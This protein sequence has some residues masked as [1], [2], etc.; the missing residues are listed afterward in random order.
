M[1]IFM[2]T[3]FALL[4]VSAALGCNGERQPASPAGDE[5]SPVKGDQKPVGAAPPGSA[6]GTTR[7][8][9]QTPAPTPTQVASAA[10]PAK[11][12]GDTSPEIFE[13]T[14]GVLEKKRPDLRPVVVREVRAGRHEGFD[15]V[16]FEIAGA[17]VP[18]YHIEYSDKPPHACGSGDAVQVAGKGW[19]EVRLEPAETTRGKGPKTLGEAARKPAL[20]VVK[21]IA[22]TCD[23]E[24][25]VV[26]VLGLASPN[27]Y[28]VLALTNPTRLVVDV[29]H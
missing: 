10:P 14:A 12:P 23:F 22:Q 28:R 8:P 11:E 15:R 13:G 21:E 2:M 7:A 29:K 4:T 19:L 1:R 5:A 24:A 17:D 16:V 18:G 3:T 6:L 25:Q 26:F 9:V 27:K 20:P